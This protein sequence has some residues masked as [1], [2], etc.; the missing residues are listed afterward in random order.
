M[1]TSQASLN[2]ANV[3]CAVRTMIAV[4]AYSGVRSAPLMN[5]TPLFI[6]SGWLELRNLSS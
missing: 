5:L 6:F 2:V 4:T 3:G 1:A